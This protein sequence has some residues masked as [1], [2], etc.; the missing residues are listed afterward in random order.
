M[1]FWKAK[2]YFEMARFNLYEVTGA[3]LHCHRV[4]HGARAVAKAN[5]GGHLLIVQNA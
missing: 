2:L 3:A 5:F 4:I 1:E